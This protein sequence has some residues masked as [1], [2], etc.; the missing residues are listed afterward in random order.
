MTKNLDAYNEEQRRRIAIT[1]PGARPRTTIKILTRHTTAE[2]TPNEEEKPKEENVE[3]DPYFNDNDAPPM[4]PE[5][6]RLLDDMF[7]FWI[8]CLGNERFS[9]TCLLHYFLYNKLYLIISR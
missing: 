5:S 4:S 6:R 1:T 9:A 3:L 2:V 8:I 7:S